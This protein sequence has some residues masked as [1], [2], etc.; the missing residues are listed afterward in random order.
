[1]MAAAG[2]TRGR[3]VVMPQ[4]VRC[5]PEEKLGKRPELCEDAQPVS[6]ET[7]SVNASVWR[8][9]S[10]SVVCGH[11]SA[12]LWNGVMRIPRLARKACR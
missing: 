9:T 1:M 2:I 6:A 3:T 4:S 7:A 11:I 8:S 12:M 10:S 5:V